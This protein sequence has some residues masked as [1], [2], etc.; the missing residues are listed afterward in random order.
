MPNASTQNAGTGQAIRVYL[1]KQSGD[2]SAVGRQPSNTIQTNGP[3]DV[4]E[5]AEGIPHPGLQ[6]PKGLAPGCICFQTYSQT[7]HVRI[8]NKLKKTSDVRHRY[9]KPCTKWRENKKASHE[10][11]FEK[12]DLGD[13]HNGWDPFRSMSTS[14]VAGAAVATLIKGG[15]HLRRVPLLR[16]LSWER[17]DYFP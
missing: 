10:R 15:E 4:A 6:D 12:P 1:K 13:Q 5:C 17:Q 9:R 14:A 7:T 16:W 2:I 11:N 3:T 8:I